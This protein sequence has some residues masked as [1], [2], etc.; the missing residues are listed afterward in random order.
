MS[1]LRQAIAAEIPRLQQCAKRLVQKNQDVDDLVQDCL[2]N[3]FTRLHNYQEGGNLQ[4][5]L[6]SALY[7]T[8]FDRL[9]AASRPK[10]SA[11]L[12]EFNEETSGQSQLAAPDSRL[13]LRDLDRA[14]ATLPKKQRVCVWLVHAERLTYKEAAAELRI[15]ENTVKSRVSRACQ[16]LRIS[17]Q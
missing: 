15:P 14:L 10:R 4:G 6:I 11:I 9:R 8:H 16:K 17:L 2:T 7:N 3:V 13:G 5:W 12:V 1:N